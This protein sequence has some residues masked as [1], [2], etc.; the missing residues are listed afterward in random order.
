MFIFQFY[1]RTY[2][3]AF[4]SSL[5]GASVWDLELPKCEFETVWSWVSYLTSLNFSF[6]IC[7][8][9]MTMSASQGSLED[10]S[11]PSSSGVLLPLPLGCPHPI[12]SPLHCRIHQGTYP[13]A[14]DL[15]P[16]QKQ[17][18]LHKFQMLNFRVKIP[19]FIIAYRM[20][21]RLLRDPKS[22]LCICPCLQIY[23]IPW[24][25]PPLTP[26]LMGLA[27]KVAPGQ[28]RNTVCTGETQSSWNECIFSSWLA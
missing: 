16:K 23:L 22:C 28:E 11:L 18:V 15:S 24:H 25:L 27:V 6:L 5:C 8:T 13:I 21:F 17:C 1:V 2:C 20:K 7:R 3:S 12:L 19:Q 10:S 26:G 9:A 14:A 4:F